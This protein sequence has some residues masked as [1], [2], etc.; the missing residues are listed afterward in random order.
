MLP[1][2][3]A[4]VVGRISAVFGVR[5]WV[6]VHSFTEPMENILQYAPWYIR[7]EQGWEPVEVAGA[8]RQ[9]KTLVAQLG[10]ETDRERARDRF[11]G[12]QLAVPRSVLPA[13]PE[14][15][16]YWRDLIGLR[17]RLEDG[18]DL[19]K[20]HSLLETGANDVLVV[21]GDGNSID[22]RERLI[23][24]VPGVYVTDVDTAAGSLTADWDPEF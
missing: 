3:D 15:E 16:F 4:L 2:A 22:Q 14:D 9:G 10:G 8:R 24:W 18:R 12:K 1:E 5:G 20:V 6:K 19:G 13:L 17:V 23:P 21:R 7:G 11:V